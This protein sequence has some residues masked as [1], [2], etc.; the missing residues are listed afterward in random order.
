MISILLAG[1]LTWTMPTVHTIPGTASPDSL[2]RLP[3][4]YYRWELGYS[5]QSKACKD[6]GLVWCRD[7][8]NI[9]TWLPGAQIKIVLY[10]YG[11]P[12][13]M[14]YQAEI[15]VISFDWPYTWWVRSF[16]GPEAPSVWS[17]PSSSRP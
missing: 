11:R 17:N 16:T 4:G 2:S 8:R 5:T 14:V 3:D 7:P 1:I 13:Q 12:G 9:S 10:G 15:P 6:S